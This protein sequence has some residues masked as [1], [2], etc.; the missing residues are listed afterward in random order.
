MEPSEK[1]VL[2]LPSEELLKNYGK[3][4]KLV[5]AAKDVL[6]L[7]FDMRETEENSEPQEHQKN[8]LERTEVVEIME[9]NVLTKT[10]S[11]NIVAVENSDSKNLLVSEAGEALG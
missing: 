11:R 1:T 10:V 4:S 3:T 9:T 2:Q 7:Q 5:I 6:N 8:P